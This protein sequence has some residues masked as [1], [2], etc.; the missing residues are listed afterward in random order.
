MRKMLS[1]V[2]PGLQQLNGEAH[3]RDKQVRSR[4]ERR[5]R[6]CAA[7]FTGSRDQLVF[8]FKDGT[9]IRPDSGHMQQVT[10]IFDGANHHVEEW[11]YV[12]NGKEETTRFD[13]AR[14]R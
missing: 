12:Q 8:K 7:R 2:T 14:K 6:D 3:P 13:F 1:K 9:N 4:D 10:F 11:T 5:P